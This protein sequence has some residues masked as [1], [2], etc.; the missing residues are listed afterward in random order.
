MKY[1]FIGCGNMGGALARA[2]SRKTKNIVICD[3]SPMAEALAEELGCGYGNSDDIACC[4]RIFLGVKPHMVAGVLEGLRPVL[5]ERKP[6]LISMAAGVST[7]QLRNFAG[8]ELP[9]IRI[10]PNTPVMV[11]KGMILYCANEFVE[12]GQTRSFLEDLSEA[13]LFDELDEKL[14]DAA[15]AVSGCGPAYVYLF[16]EALADGAVA[17]GLPRDKAQRYAAATLAGAAEMVLST[18]KH[19]GALKDAVCS[20]GGSTIA[21]VKALENHGFR[22]AVMDCVVD[23]YARTLELGK[24]K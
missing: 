24:G 17:C 4:D 16:I 8:C 12:Q 10:M 20:P 11:G 15:S 6:L 7:N 5:A 1:G 19:P 23:A 18:G 3:P 13:G 9:I 22:G 21:G 2:L 14:I